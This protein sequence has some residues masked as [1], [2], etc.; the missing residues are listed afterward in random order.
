MQLVYQTPR[1]TVTELLRMPPSMEPLVE[2]GPL[3][4]HLP[5]SAFL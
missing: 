5:L 4:L 3:Q 2:T 1:P